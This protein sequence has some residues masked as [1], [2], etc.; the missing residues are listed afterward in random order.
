VR[1]IDVKNMNGAEE[2]L[3]NLVIRALSHSERK[4]ILKIV[5]S[6]PEG[7]N[8]TGI[9]GESGLSTGKLNYH[10]GELTGFLERGD[11]R[12]YGVTELGRKAISVLEYIYQDI[13]EV[14]IKT[15]NTKRKI[16]L[17]SIR[18]SLD[19]GFYIAT[20]ALAGTTVIS[21]Y[22]AWVEKDQILSLVTVFVGAL[23]AFLIYNMNR[24]RKR[25]PERI[26]WFW[27]WLEWK[28]FSG[29]RSQPQE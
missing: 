13:D 7:V 25:D 5:A 4:N 27:E 28:L 16:R 12:L 21:G 19:V 2:T 17:R 26:L 22:F 10:L 6:Y 8:Y 24:S 11:D 18:R 9:L 20:I 29:F 3:E 23:S 14:S 15:L 1:L